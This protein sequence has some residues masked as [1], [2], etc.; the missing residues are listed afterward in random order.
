MPTPITQYAQPSD[1]PVY[2][3]SEDA[4]SGIPPEAVEQSLRGASS[5][6]DSAF[7]SRFTMPLF[8]VDQ[9]TVRACCVLAVYDLLVVRGYNPAAGADENLRLRVQD[10]NSWLKQV[11]SGLMTPDVTDSSTDIVPGT[12]AT[13]ARVVSASSRGWNSRGET[14]RPP[15]FFRGD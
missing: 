3:I 10:A 6:I 14:S 13:R 8:T 5:M 1:I 2:G 12:D 9:A 7:R 15:G 4:I 11:A